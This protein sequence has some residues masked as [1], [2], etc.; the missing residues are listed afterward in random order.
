MRRIPFFL[1]LFAGFVV[2]LVT[3]YGF[4]LL[5]QRPGLPPEMFKSLE[6]KIKE[7]E[8]VRIQNVEI[9]NLKMDLEFLISQKAIGDYAT[10][11]LEDDG[12]LGE[13]EVKLVPFY[14]KPFPLI[15]LLIGFFCFITG[16]T[17]FLLRSADRRARTYYCASFAFGSAIAIS[18]GFYCLQMNW[19]SFL[20]GVLYY[21]FYPLAPAILLH[22]SLYFS[23][24]EAKLW[25]I[26]IY[27]P[28]FIFVCVLEWIF[29]SA[30]LSSSIEIHRIY[31]SV[32]D[33]HRFYLVVY[34]SLSVASLVISYKKAGLEEEKAQIKWIFYGL[35]VGLGPFI[36][37]YQLPQVLGR[38]EL[39]SEEFS[40]LFFIF[41]PLAFAFS[42]VKFKLMDVEL[43]INRSLVYFTLTV[44]TVG[45]YLFSVNLIQNVVSRFFTAPRTAISVIAALLAAVAFHPARK[46]IQDFVDRAFY[47]MSYDYRKTILRFNEKAYKMVNRGRLIDLFLQ[48]VKQ[49]L[50][51]EY[52][53]IFIY[54][55]ESG[56]QKLLIAK[57]KRIDLDS[58]VSLSLEVEKIFA[59]KEAVR[60][61]E[62]MDFSKESLLSEKDID[63]VMPLSFKSSD[64]TGFLSLGRKKSGEKFSG[65]DIE[66]LLT[67]SRDL[68]LNLERIRLLEEV[69][70]ERVEREKLN[71]LIQL[72]T[73][74]ISSVS[75]ELRTPM[76]SIRGLAEILQEGKIKDKTKQEELIRLVATESNRLS[77]FL[78][79]ILDFGKIEH[80]GKAYT[81]QKV[82]IVSLIIEAVKLFQYRSD[83]DEF[84]FKTQLPKKSLF[85]EIDQDAVKQALTNLLDNAIKY[86]SD[87]K[88]IVIELVREDKHVEIRVKDRGIGIPA[89]E[90]EKIFEGFYRQVD[91]D[92]HSPKGVGLGLKIV[93]HIMKAHGGEVSVESQSGKGSVFSLIFPAP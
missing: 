45:L 51:M 61:E 23:K 88:E 27:I 34:V 76:S 90:H 84:V 20:P 7:G 50:P 80:S 26:V 33:F 44:F 4:S 14:D 64:L 42:I 37:F 31:Q 49:T 36:L 77:R 54:G 79:N 18:G 82:E 2:I 66:L 6:K 46:K 24:H 38:N 65:D 47:R 85:L 28:A 48:K 73:E 78:H 3:V 83:S 12:K 81:F 17:V 25:R 93:K 22:F 41:V 16:T 55:M 58:L 30:G 13:Q 63:L 1:S 29:L 11:V 89:E 35:F 32:F 67:L 43:V 71:E 39:V 53:G 21:L 68:A 74:F 69:I 72:K 56:E 91:A 59:R 75:H 19:L 87:K 5:R 15:Y 60:T 9:Q 52:V 62:N 70:Y 92:R 10:V 8:L 57:D 40:T 86:S